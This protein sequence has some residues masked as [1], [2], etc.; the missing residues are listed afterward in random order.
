MD[1]VRETLSNVKKLITAGDHATAWQTLR[2]AVHT[3][4]TILPCKRV[5]KAIFTNPSE[6]LQLTPIKTRTALFQ[7]CRSFCRYFEVLVCT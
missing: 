2:M 1:T 6:T 5:R 4:M 7:H 3:R